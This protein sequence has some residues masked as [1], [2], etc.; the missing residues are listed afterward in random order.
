MREYGVSLRHPNK[1]FQIKQADREE[2]VFEY[3]KDIWTVRKFVLDN[4][5]LDPPVINGDQM[6]LHRNESSFQKTLNFTG[7]DT[8][9]KENY[10][11]SRERVTVFTQVSSDP[12]LTLKPEFVFKGKG[13]RTSLHPPDG[14]KYNWAPKGSY[15][16][17]QMLYTISNL[18]NRYNIFTPENYAIYV[19]DDY[20]VHIMPEIKEA[21]LKTGY[22]PVIIG[23]GVTGDI[24]INDTDLHSPLKAKYRELE[25][26][27]I[28][29]QLKANPKKIPRPSRV[30]MMRMLSESFEID[31]VMHFKSLW[32]TNALDGSK[33]YLVSERIIML[34]GEKLKVFRKKLNKADS[35]KNLK[36]LLKLITPPK[37]VKKKGEKTAVPVDEGKE[38]FDCDGEE[39]NHEPLLESDDSDQDDEEN[40]DPAN[41]G[42][43]S[44]TENQQT[45]TVAAVLLARIV[46]DNPELE[47]DAISLDNLGTPLSTS[48]TSDKFIPFM[49]NFKQNYIAACRAIKKRI[50]C[51]KKKVVA[52]EEGD[53]SDVGDDI[54]NF[55][56]LFDKLFA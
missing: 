29:D 13:T 50:L 32:V 42:E 26:L 47:K 41:E 55:A 16:L 17:E 25:Q 38:L 21:F 28:T 56:N 39:L 15:C 22:V 34:V 35:P 31:V 51:S 37:G 43:Q 9:V 52:C 20:S 18:P 19:L 14:I 5:G 8:Y 30:D 1:R 23:G 33:D 27:L 6:P 40:G 54:D 49:N 46:K 4:F 53:P 7:M 11:L 45:T 3:L 12:D 44:Q 36:D 10:N 24:Q 2:R 48:D